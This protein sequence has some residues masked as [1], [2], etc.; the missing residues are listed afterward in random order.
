MRNVKDKLKDKIDVAADATQDRGGHV[1]EKSKD[2]A[3]HAGE[4]L[5]RGGK[6]LRTT[7]PWEKLPA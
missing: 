6:R 3:D 5:A 1:V 7:W 2:V 4:Q